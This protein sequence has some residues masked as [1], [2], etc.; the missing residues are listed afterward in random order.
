MSGAVGLYVQPS[1]LGKFVRRTSAVDT[2]S[3][4]QATDDS[5]IIT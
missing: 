3:N 5:D 2:A 4:R 1:K